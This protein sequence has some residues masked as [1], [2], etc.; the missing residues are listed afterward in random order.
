MFPLAISEASSQRI[1][2]NPR[3]ILAS[4]EEGLASKAL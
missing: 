3:Q 2:K 4:R 1:E